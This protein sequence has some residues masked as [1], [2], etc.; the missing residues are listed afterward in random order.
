MEAGQGVLKQSA[1]GLLSSIGESIGQGKDPLKA[2]LKIILDMLGDWLIQLGA[3]L[4]FASAA[5]LAA[6]PLTFG[7]TLAPGAMHQI[8][9]GLMIVA[10]GAVKGYAYASICKFC[11]RLSRI[12]YSVPVIVVFCFPYI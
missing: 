5:L 1:V 3:A 7:I 2:G 9:G 4:L 8:A 12:H 11:E 10:G 6:A